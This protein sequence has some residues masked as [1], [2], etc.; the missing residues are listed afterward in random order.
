MASLLARTIR[1]TEGRGSAADWWSCTKS[2]CREVFNRFL[3]SEIFRRRLE[4]G[5]RNAIREP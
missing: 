3:E 1:T 4:D 5:G 2:Q